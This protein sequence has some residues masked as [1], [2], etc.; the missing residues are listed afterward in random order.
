MTTETTLKLAQIDNIIGIKEASSD[1]EQI[2]NIIKNSPENFRVWSGNDD[3]T[4]GIMTLGGF[5]IVSVASNII[6]NQI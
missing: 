5:G 2:T 4:F 1:I 3:E 6:G